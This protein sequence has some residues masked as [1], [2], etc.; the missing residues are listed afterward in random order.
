MPSSG[1]GTAWD[2]T[3]PTDS[4]N[5]SDIPVE[6]RDVRKG[7]EIREKKEHVLNAGSS[8]GGEHKQGAAVSYHQNS[9][10]TLRPDGSTTLDASDKGRLW[11][12]ATDNSLW[13]WDGTAW[14]HSTITALA[15]IADGL[16]TKDKIASGFTGG[17]YPIA[18]IVDSKSDGVDGGTFTSGAWRT[19]ELNTTVCDNGT[20]TSLASN[21]ITLDA[22]T[23]RVKASAPAQQVD[24]HQVR[25]RNI[26]N[27]NTLFVGTSAYAA[28][29]TAVVS[30]SELEGEFTVSADD[31]VFE[32]QHICT[33]SKSG[34]GFG[35][36][37]SFSVGE[38]YAMVTLV[39]LL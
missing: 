5:V 3:L 26:T 10:P 17:I 34:S 21:Q 12:K 1:D 15:A 31:T 13:I 25:W 20:F 23:Y 39:K 7:V 22:G 24:A 28:N 2:A 33:T 4:A 6:I 8:V 37:G 18:V 36:H 38:V 16:I 30:R 11:L 35:L 9:A 19:R 29:G 32:L 27:A 14:Q